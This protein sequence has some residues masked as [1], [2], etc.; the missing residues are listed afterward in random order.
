MKKQ[1]LIAGLLIIL[2]IYVVFVGIPIIKFESEKQIIEMK[3]DR[4][5]FYKEVEIILPA[6]EESGEGVIAILKVEV[7]EGKGRTL[8][9]INDISFL[10]DT[11]ES[12]RNAKTVAEKITGMDTSNYDII[13]SINANASKIE[14][15]SAGP[16]IAI[17]TI[18]GLENKTINNSVVITGYLR[19]DGKIT[20]V[21][22]IL[23][24]VQ[25]AKDNHVQLFLVPLGQRIETKTETKKD[26]EN[27]AYTTFCTTKF[28]ETKVDIQEEVGIDVV[29]VGAISDALKYFIVD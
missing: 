2:L 18:I 13:Y 22:G 7:T 17:A 25:S 1:I 3:P 28:V 21:S 14:G 5:K 27:S 20:K 9:E 10:D 4:E 23:A 29:E 15:P 16:A 6:V 11:Q 12:I 19:E 24:K 26:C 8:V